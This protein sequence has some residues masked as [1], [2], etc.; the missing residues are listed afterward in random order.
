M[1]LLMFLEHSCWFCFPDTGG[2]HHHSDS[3]SGP[4]DEPDDLSG[5]ESGEESVSYSAPAE[6]TLSRD[7]SEPLFEVEF[8]TSEPQPDTEDLLGLNSDP[9]PLTVAPETGMKTCSSN[10]DLLNDLFSSAPA[11]SHTGD[12]ED[13]FFSSTSSQPSAAPS[14]TAPTSTAPKGTTLSC[15]MGALSRTRI[16]K[17]LEFRRARTVLW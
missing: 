2:P 5:G 6:G 11:P 9:C 1:A 13:L 16:W 8:P 12:A 14:T 3:A 10:S 4:T 15:H 7:A 17:T